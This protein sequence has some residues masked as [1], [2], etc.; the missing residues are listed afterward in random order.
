[1]VQKYQILCCFAWAV[2]G[3]PIGFS[4]K[5]FKTKYETSTAF[6]LWG[7][8]PWGLRPNDDHRIFRNI[9]LKNEIVFMPSFGKSVRR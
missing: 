8:A 5:V 4:L 2:F 6:T 3:C 7:V 1:M 9:F